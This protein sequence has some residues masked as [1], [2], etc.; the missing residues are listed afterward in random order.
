MRAF[1]PDDVVLDLFGVAKTYPGP[2]PVTALDG[3]N[4][5]IHRGELVAIV[6]PSGSGKS[7]LLNIMGGLDRPTAGSV[8]IEGND[9]VEMSDRQVSGIRAT[10]MGFVF[11]E[12]FLIS[13]TSA[14]DNV[15]EGLRYRG[16]SR[17]ARLD[18]AQSA[19]DQVGLSHRMDHLPTQLS[20]GE[21]QRVAIARAL[22]GGPAI[23]FADEPT[24][25]LDSKTSDDIV[26]LLENLNRAGSTI[27]VITHDLEVA[28]RFPRRIEIRD[29]RIAGEQG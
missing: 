19:L 22:V 14:I 1:D 17:R 18:R 29:G 16:M 27:V 7:T 2:P 13:G 20:G 3:V 6:G 9:I 23:V 12:F 4:V 5:R 24:G 28:G 25:N 26:G 8:A 21:R 10:L 11:Q 15:A